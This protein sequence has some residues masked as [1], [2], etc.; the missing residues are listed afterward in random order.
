MR[1][2]IPIIILSI[3]VLSCKN[4][5]NVDISDEE[6][7]LISPLQNHV[8]SLQDKTFSWEELEDVDHY[9]L[10]IVSPSFDSIVELV[11]D[12]P[13]AI[14]FFSTSL[15]PGTYQWRVRGQNE[16][17]NTKWA[18]RNLEVS[19]TASLNGQEITGVSPNT[20]T[21]SNNMNHTFIWNELTS[22]NNYL[23]IVEDNSNTQIS[24]QNIE[25]ESYNYTFPTEG[26]FTVKIQGLNNLSASVQKEISIQ[27]D[28][29]I[30]V[31][32]TYDYPA[33]DTIKSFPQAFTWTAAINTGSAITENLII[34]SDS[35]MNNVLL[36]TTLN[37]YNSIQLDSV[38]T[39]GLL[40]WRIKRL[41]AAGN[42]SQNEP[43]QRFWIF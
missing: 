29:T 1:N 12:S 37:G 3:V 18:V 11:L 23:I 7:T 21:N 2:I 8:D 22:A 31:N 26:V 35:L 28:T 36:D 17:F 43:S 38:N 14:T 42:E 13:V 40:Y 32:I 25:V 6:V 24:T 9:Q 19:N 27:I 15:T 20:G 10:Q 34:A 41:D 16:D 4:W 5:V 30:P 39:N 33:Y